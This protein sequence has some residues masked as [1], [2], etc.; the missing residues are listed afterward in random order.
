MTG[1]PAP[2]GHPGSNRDDADAPHG[3]SVPDAAC[4]SVGDTS[5]V[6][7]RPMPGSPVPGGSVFLAALGDR[8]AGLRSEVLRYVSGAGVVGGEVPVEGTFAVAGSKLR[9][10]NHLARPLVG[11]FLF[12]TAHERDVP[13]T[14]VNRVAWEPGHGLGLQAERVFEFRSGA[15]RFV[16]VL[17]PGEAAGTLTNLLGEARRVELEL[18]CSV[19]GEGHLRLD[20][21]RAWLRLGR[22]RL[23][24]PRLVSVRAVVE[25]GFDDARGVHTVAARVR[26]PLIGTVLEYRGTFR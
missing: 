16:D 13:F 2:R 12:V 11:P 14:V 20:S 25:D 22:L 6:A 1:T 23:R 15:Q 7:G 24:L 3:A 17:L 5:Q 19:T 10:L 21:G 9:W 18:H 4:D 8:A 26:N